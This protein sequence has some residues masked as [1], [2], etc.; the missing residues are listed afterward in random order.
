MCDVNGRGPERRERERTSNMRG[1]GGGGGPGIPHLS[2]GHE[3]PRAQHPGRS[4]NE[5]HHLRRGHASLEVDVAWVW[6]KDGKDN[7]TTGTASGGLREAW[8]KPP[9]ARHLQLNHRDEGFG[10][11]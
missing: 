2:V 3:A 1:R 7:S 4:A 8:T 9:T 5:R 11:I 10:W 6:G